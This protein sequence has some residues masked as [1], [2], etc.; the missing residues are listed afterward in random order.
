MDPLAID[1]LVLGES[2]PWE[3]VGGEWYAYGRGPGLLRYGL[4]VRKT[5]LD[6]FGNALTAET[7]E[8][9][10]TVFE[11]AQSDSWRPHAWHRVRSVHRQPFATVEDAQQW[12][13]TRM[14]ILI[15]EGK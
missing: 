7:I 5:K 14:A 4:G 8:A 1:P 11:A 13:T 12:A 2:S 10:V 9:E 3:E 15:K 6:R